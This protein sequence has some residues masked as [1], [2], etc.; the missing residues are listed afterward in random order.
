MISSAL[1]AHAYG[2]VL[3]DSFDAWCS[4][5]IHYKLDGSSS[6]VCPTCLQPVH[7]TQLYFNH[8]CQKIVQAVQSSQQTTAGKLQQCLISVVNIKHSWTLPHVAGTSAVTGRQEDK[9]CQAGSASAEGPSMQQLSLPEPE[10]IVHPASTVCRDKAQQKDVTALQGHQQHSGVASEVEDCS[11]VRQAATFPLQRAQAAAG[12]QLQVYAVVGADYAMQRASQAL[13]FAQTVP[14]AGNSFSMSAMAQLPASLW[15]YNHEWALEVCQ[16]IR[17]ANA[18]CEVTGSHSHCSA[19]IVHAYEH[20]RPA[21]HT[22][23]T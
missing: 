7:L 4:S 3:P 17:S 11:N 15:R 5:C 21:R 20:Q 18:V 23:Q 2:A 9:G 12:V 19:C 10:L 14:G 8:Q 6:P 1:P 22:A 16:S 13:C